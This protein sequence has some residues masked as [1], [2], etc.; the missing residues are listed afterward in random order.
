MELKLRSSINFL[1]PNKWLLLE[2]RMR[3]RSKKWSSRKANY[4]KTSKAVVNCSL[5]S[6]TLLTALSRVWTR[7]SLTINL[8]PKNSTLLLRSRSLRISRNRKIKSL[9]ISR[10]FRKCSKIIKIYTLLLF[11]CSKRS[12]LLGRWKKFLKGVRSMKRQL[13]RPNKQSLSRSLISWMPCSNWKEVTNTS[14]WV[15]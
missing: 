12:A 3:T 2:T 10:V 8:P 5:K 7:C 15:L 13:I 9:T 4:N 6:R 14:Y 11:R 1:W